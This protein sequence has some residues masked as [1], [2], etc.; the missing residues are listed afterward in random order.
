M[1]F[2]RNSSPRAFPALSLLLLAGGC[3]DAP[4]LE[5]LADATKV[6]VAK[7]GSVRKIGLVQGGGTV[8][9]LTHDDRRYRN[10]DKALAL[11][12]EAVARTAVEAIG[13][14]IP[15][16][17]VRVTLVTEDLNLGVYRSHSSTST[18]FAV[19]QLNR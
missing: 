2:S 5:E 13:G 1:R 12:M 18:A 14:R 10:S 8:L 19:S 9:E 4:A 16:D 11:E 3:A 7:H 15:L 6:V 17:S